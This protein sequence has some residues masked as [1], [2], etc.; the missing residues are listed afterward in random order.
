MQAAGGKGFVKRFL[1]NAVDRKTPTQHLKAPAEEAEV[2][3]SFSKLRQ[4]NQR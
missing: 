3:N 4:E 2:H 1:E